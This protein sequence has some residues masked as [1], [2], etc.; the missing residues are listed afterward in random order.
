[1]KHIFI[2]AMLAALS[3]CASEKIEVMKS[4]CASLSDDCGPKR[5][6]NEWWLPP[7]K[8]V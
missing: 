6:V 4:P 1:M 3:A 5:P 8:Q 7:S 2:I